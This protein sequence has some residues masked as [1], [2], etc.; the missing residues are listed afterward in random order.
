MGKCFL[1]LLATTFPSVQ[2]RAAGSKNSNAGGQQRQGLL[3]IGTPS[4]FVPPRSL[5]VPV[6]LLHFNT[7]YFNTPENW[8]CC[9]EAEI[10]LLLS[11]K[12]G[13]MKK[14]VFGYRNLAITFCGTLHSVDKLSNLINI[15][16]GGL[17]VKH[18][19]LCPS[20]PLHVLLQAGVGQLLSTSF[21]F[22]L[23]L[24]V[25]SDESS[26]EKGSSY[27]LGMLIT[28]ACL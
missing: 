20:F 28:V 14:C 3:S 1:S 8:F 18:V 5:L 22:P 21:S 10:I 24:K 6:G 4:C 2:S 16:G 23:C 17:W 19:L 9:E 27:T 26:P 11:E 7:Q 13:F 15:R 25:I 12:V